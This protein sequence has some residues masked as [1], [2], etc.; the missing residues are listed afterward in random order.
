MTLQYQTEVRTETDPVVIATLKR[1]G[2]VQIADP[3]PSVP[4]VEQAI[5]LGFQ[6]VYKTYSA[7]DI[8]ILLGLPQ[9]NPTNT[10]I[11][12]GCAAILQWAAGLYAAARAT[13]TTFNPVSPD[14]DAPI[15]RAECVAKGYLPA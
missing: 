8:N 9:T 11:I 6:F 5:A 10:Q 14:N 1:K 15:T 2:W 4:T 13:P 12:T 7:A 3:A